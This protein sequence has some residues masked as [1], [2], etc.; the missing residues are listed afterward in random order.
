[1]SSNIGRTIKDSYCNGY[2]G[3]DYDFCNSVI[4]A[5]GDEYLVIR[6]ENDIVC[7][8]NFQNWN[9]NRND[10][11]TLSYGISDLSCMSYED[12]QKLIDSWCKI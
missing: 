11:G 9:Y 7:F 4:I 5:E 10:D 1:M 2:F 8:C 12:R 3:R 6:K